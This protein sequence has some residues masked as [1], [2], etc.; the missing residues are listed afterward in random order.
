MATCWVSVRG[1]REPTLLE[2][3]LERGAIERRLP[4]HDAVTFAPPSNKGGTAGLAWLGQHLVVATWDSVAVVDPAT[5]STEQVWTDRRFSDLHGLCVDHR[6]RILVTSTNVDGVFSITEGGI[7]PLWY[8]TPE[9]HALIEADERDLRRHSKHDVPYHSL[10]VNDVEVLGDTMLITFLG[11]R[12]RGP[13]IARLA[14]KLLGAN[15][16]RD[17]RLGWRWY[18]GGVIVVDEATGQQRQALDCEGLHDAV[19]K[20]DGSVHST[21][22]FGAALSEYRD[23]TLRRVPLDPG[24]GPAYLTRAILFV[25]DRMWVGH[26]VLRH[27]EEHAPPALLREYALDG[28]WL[29]GEVLLPDCVG[30]YALVPSESPTGG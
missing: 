3:D 2:V 20:G 4:V 27:A 8:P 16:A 29:G 11:T 15:P 24:P 18:D 10:H 5:G 9:H 28:T 21:E 22:Y 26:T 1:D 30:P 12:G 17:R 14:A 7:E 19:A 13:A 25:D 6:G 23:G